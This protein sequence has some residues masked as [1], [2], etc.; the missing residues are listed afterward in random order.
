M[1][2]YLFYGS[3]AGVIFQKMANDDLK[4]NK[5]VSY[6]KNKSLDLSLN[7]IYYFSRFQIYINKNIS[8]K[9]N[10]YKNKIIDFI[11]NNKYSRENLFNKY[12]IYLFKDGEKYYEIFIDIFKLENNKKL[13]IQ[14][15]YSNFVDIE[16][17]IDEKEYIYDYNDISSNKELEDKYI[18][19]IIEIINCIKTK[20]TLD[21]NLFIIKNKLLNNN[22]ICDTITRDSFNFEKSNIKFFSLKITDDTCK[23]YL[24]ELCNNE[25]NFY[26]VN[27]CIDE[28]F[29]KY[30]LRQILN[31][32]II[33]NKLNYKLDI[34][35]HNVEFKVFLNNHKIIINK[36]DYTVIEI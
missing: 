16:E 29:I 22:I 5:I 27:N 9:I 28:K 19:R 26:M 4:A 34:I 33:N 2:K 18:Q 20:E 25:S 35:D 11:I 1:L 12:E 32:N 17:K 15:K 21:N 7:L 8:P 13:I 3:I 36:N 30:Y 6:I 10:F 14:I 24:I 23:E 31:I